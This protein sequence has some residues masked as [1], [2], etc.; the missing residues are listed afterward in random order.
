MVE[1][2]RTGSSVRF[3]CTAGNGM[4]TFLTEEVKKKLLAED[5]CQLHGKVLFSSSAAIH[6]IT[7]LKAAERLFLLLKKDS[8]LRMPTRC[9][10]EAAFLLQ[11]RLLGNRDQW[12]SAAVTW[13][14]LQR[15]LSATR[16]LGGTRWSQERGESEDFAGSRKHRSELREPESEEQHEEKP[17][18][19]KRMRVEDGDAEMKR[20]SNSFSSKI[21]HT[22]DDGTS[23]SVENVTFR[24]SCKCSGSV[25]RSFSS[26]EVSK[27]MGPAVSKLMGWKA[28]LKNPL[29][30]VSLHLSDDYCLLGIPLTRLPLANRSYI[31]TTGLRSTVAWAMASLAHIQPGFCVVDPMCGVGTILIE[32]AQEHQDACFLGV[33]IDDGQLQRANENVAFADLGQRIQ[34]LKASTVALPL[35]SGSVDA[36]ICDLPFGKK[37]GRGTNMAAD[38]PLILCEMERILCP[39]GILVVLLSPQLSCLL[40]KLLTQEPQEPAEPALDQ[41]AKPQTVA[42]VCL[43]S[44]SLS[45]QQLCRQDRRPAADLQ[46]RPCP[47]WSSLKHQVTFRVSLGAIDG[48]IHKYIKI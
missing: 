5:V 24:I 10:R 21:L 14:C 17:S 28:D 32:A 38:L 25:S 36:V 8:P 18:E 6:R 2:S 29:L 23:E 41:K 12:I 46:Q 26:Q 27:M 31:K 34:L 43:S 33:D 13:S 40:K 7:G 47:R 4:E 48:L 11:S 22:G 19:K 3:F 39:G 20:E 35:P 9:S 15:E 44:S 37:F 42:A 30:E 16:D 1:P 45:D